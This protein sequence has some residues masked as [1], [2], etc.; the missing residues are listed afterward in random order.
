MSQKSFALSF[1]TCPSQ[2]PCSGTGRWHMRYSVSLISRS[3]ARIRSA[4]VCCTRM[5]AP[6]GRLA[7]ICVKTRKSKVS[8][9]R[10]PYLVLNRT[11]REWKMTPREW[12]MAKAQ[13]TVLF[14]ERFTRAIA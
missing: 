7:Q 8:G 3:L 11:E 14:G 13:F 5:N 4:M 10:K 1:L 6:P 9:F 12:A 2:R